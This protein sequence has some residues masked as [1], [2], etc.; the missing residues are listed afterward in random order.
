MA[1]LSEF[2]IAH[3]HQEAIRLDQRE[4]LFA[5]PMMPINPTFMR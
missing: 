4:P 3:D 2:Y 1:K 5:Q